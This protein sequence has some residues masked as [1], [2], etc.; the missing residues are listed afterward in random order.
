MIVKQPFDF[1]GKIDRGNGWENWNGVVRRGWKVRPTEQLSKKL[2]SKR[3]LYETKEEK[4]AY[5]VHR[6]GSWFD[7]VYGTKTEVVQGKSNA[8]AKRNALNN[9]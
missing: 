5:I 3:L 7:V 9:S 2:M 1:K 4:R 8:E 6:G